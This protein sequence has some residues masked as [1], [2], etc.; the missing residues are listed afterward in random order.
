MNLV[1]ETTNSCRI[2]DIKNAYDVAMNES[3]MSGF[4]DSLQSNIPN[5]IIGRGGS[6]IWISEASTKERIA[7]ITNLFN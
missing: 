3:T 6:H 1:I 4:I 7:M 2:G 5:T